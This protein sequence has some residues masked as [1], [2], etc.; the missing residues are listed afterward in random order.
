MSYSTIALIGCVY[1]RLCSAGVPEQHITILSPTERIQQFEPIVIELQLTI[2]EDSSGNREPEYQG[3]LRHLAHRRF[4]AELHDTSHNIVAEARLYGGTF[5]KARENVRMLKRTLFGCFGTPVRG[6]PKVPFMFFPNTGTFM[7]IVR[8]I[9]W[10]FRSNTIVLDIQK[11]INAKAAALFATP[12]QDTLALLFVFERSEPAS[13][14]FHELATTYADTIWGTYAR[15]ALFVH[16][17]RQFTQQPPS[18]EPSALDTVR[19]LSSRLAP[20]HPLRNHTLLQAA[21]MQIALERD[22]EAVAILRQLADE[23]GDESICHSARSYLRRLS[24]R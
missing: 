20:A 12:G 5:T 19:A 2:E 22:E 7:V 1:V 23:A 4:V 9:D 3:I 10:G 16:E 8:D 11:A 21:R 13:P 14:H 17:S 6:D 24:E 15:L 18:Y